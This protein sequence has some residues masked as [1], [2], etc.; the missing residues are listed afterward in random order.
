MMDYTWLMAYLTAEFPRANLLA[1]IAMA[2]AGAVEVRRVHG[3]RL[4]WMH[5][6]ILTTV[7][8]NGG[9]ALAP[10]W[11]NTS[12]NTMGG[13]DFQIACCVAAYFLV[14][15][16]PGG[17][18]LCERRPVALVLAAFSGLYRATRV[19]TFT[20]QGYETF[21]KYEPVSYYHGF[22]SD[23]SHSATPSLYPIPVFGPILFGTLFGNMGGY[24]QKSFHGRMEKTG[25][26]VSFLCALISAAF[27][28]FFVHDHSGFVGPA[29][30]WPI[31]WLVQSH[32]SSSIDDS[33]LAMI[34]VS[35][36]LQIAG[37]GPIVMEMVDSWYKDESLLVV[38]I[39]E[40]KEC[41]ILKAD[42]VP[43]LIKTKTN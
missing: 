43:A 2:I 41:I 11:M 35:G 37:L 22:A 33:R 31:H 1:I 21:R 26:P 32:T 27:Y 40:V 8:G 12:K 15:K 13:N 23:P 6:M 24:L 3:D 39:A 28:H 20:S 38:E 9:S 7:C 16:I 29:L 4:H 10:M 17:Y 14:Q 5:A 25:L 19:V 36:F 42:E 18:S 34:L 30:R